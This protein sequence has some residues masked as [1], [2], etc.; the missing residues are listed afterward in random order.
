MVFR[1]SVNFRRRKKIYKKAKDNIKKLFD[2]D[3]IKSIMQNIT[4][5]NKKIERINKDIFKYG[6]NIEKEKTL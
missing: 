2:Y 3:N 4:E 5:H 1:R 6:K